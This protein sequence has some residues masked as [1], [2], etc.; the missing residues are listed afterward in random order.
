MKTHRV[1]TRDYE[2]RLLM[3]EM[4]LPNASTKINLDKISISCIIMSGMKKVCN[5]G[6]QG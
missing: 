3:D 5:I 1:D 6:K 2:V 4:I